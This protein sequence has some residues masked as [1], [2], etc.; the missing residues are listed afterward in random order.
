MGM[1]TLFST[2]Q[3][4]SH[5]FN[6]VCP[7]ATPPPSMTYTELKNTYTEW[8]PYPGTTHGS[9]KGWVKANDLIALRN[10]AIRM[11][12]VEVLQEYEYNVIARRYGVRMKSMGR[13]EYGF[14]PVQGF[15]TMFGGV[16]IKNE[17]LPKRLRSG[18]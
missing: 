1:A 7:T 12:S 16:T 13:E 9:G 6:G 3:T 10:N 14:S 4:P 11:N 17:W 5:A 2:A 15:N 8:A 18:K